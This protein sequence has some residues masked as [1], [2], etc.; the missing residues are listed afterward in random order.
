M[1]TKEWKRQRKDK[2][3][4]CAR[5][6]LGDKLKKLWCQC[7]PRYEGLCCKD[8]SHVNE[9]EDKCLYYLVM[10]V[11]NKGCKFYKTLEE[12]IFEKVIPN[13]AQA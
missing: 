5:V 3:Q 1:S 4:C 7:K 11:T 6:L 10:S 2:Q 13:E 8:C 12:A 9:C